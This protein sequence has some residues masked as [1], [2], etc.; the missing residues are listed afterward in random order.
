MKPGEEGEEDK[1]A[2]EEGEESG[3]EERG[4]EGEEEGGADGEEGQGDEGD[5]ELDSEL[6]EDWEPWMVIDDEGEK[7][8]EDFPVPIEVNAEEEGGKDQ[9][10]RLV[11]LNREGELE[12]ISLVLNAEQKRQRDSD[13]TGVAYENFQL[14]KATRADRVRVG[15]PS[16]TDYEAPIL[17]EKT[18]VWMKIERDDMQPLVSAQPTASSAIAA[19]A[20]VDAEGKKKGRKRQ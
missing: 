19:A 13:L 10:G 15:R 3:E 16:E 1:D 12:A 2:R 18:I 17:M 7:E 5:E 14:A 8:E 20:A 9:F 6:D 11:V 4:D